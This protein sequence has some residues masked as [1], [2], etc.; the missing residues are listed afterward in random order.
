MNW[1]PATRVGSHSAPISFHTI[2]LSPF[3]A[4]L[5]WQACPPEPASQLS[6]AQSRDTQ[7]SLCVVKCAPATPFLSRACVLFHFPYPVTPVFATHT[8]TAGCVP[9]IPILELPIVCS[10]RESLGLRPP[11]HA[12]PRRRSKTR[13]GCHGGPCPPRRQRWALGR[14]SPILFPGRRWG[15]RTAR[16]VG[17]DRGG[18][19]RQRQCDRQAYRR[20]RYKRA[21]CRARSGSAE[22][23]VRRRASQTFP[24]GAE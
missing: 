20:R 10:R 8:K 11:P 16:A 13:S 21:R 12:C 1:T 2:P 4:C 14:P 19:R 24:R 22:G 9:T 17:G 15:P 7:F 23:R 5:P 6:R 3:F 18:R